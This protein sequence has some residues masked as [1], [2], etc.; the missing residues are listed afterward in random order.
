M[1]ATNIKKSYGT[2]NFSTAVTQC[3]VGGGPTFTLTSDIS[4]EFQGPQDHLQLDNVL[5]VLTEFI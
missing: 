1:N 2:Y 4:L 3:K 5:E